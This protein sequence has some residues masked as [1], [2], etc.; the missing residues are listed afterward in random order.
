MENIGYLALVLGFCV[1]A[2]SILAGI[3]GRLRNNAFLELSAQ[4][5]VMTVWALTTVAAGLLL[6]AILTDDF[7]LNYVAS[8]SSL[9]QPLVYRF[10][11]W[12]GGQEGSLLF[13]TWIAATYSFVAVYTARKKHA[14][15][16]SYVVAITMTIVGF[17]LGIVAFVANPFRVLMSGPQIATIADGNGLNPLLQHP[18]MAIHPPMLYL[19]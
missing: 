4:R 15:M 7:R 14:D 2:Y 8:Y 1:A 13:W 9:S 10:A 12:W 16:I 17:F 19:G 18:L 11:A 5:G 3:V 6:A